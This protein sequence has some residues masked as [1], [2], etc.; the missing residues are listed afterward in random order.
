[1]NDFDMDLEAVAPWLMRVRRAPRA[2]TGLWCRATRAGGLMFA[3]KPPPGGEL[4]EG[5]RI[6]RTRDGGSYEEIAETATESFVLPPV[7]FNDGWFY[8][9]SAFNSGGQGPA[10]GVYF[11]LR[12]HRGSI[13]QYVL[14]RAGLRVNICEFV[15][16]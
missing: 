15:R 7:A 3:W 4:V 6:E 10:N 12:R 13:L 11:Y 14:V 8:R 2:V 5:Y 16:Q 1:M 9:V